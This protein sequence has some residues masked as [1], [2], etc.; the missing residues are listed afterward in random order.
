MRFAIAGDF[1]CVG[2]TDETFASIKAR[3]PTTGAADQL[4]LF[5]P[6]G[7]LSY[8]S[9]L[10]CFV[11]LCQTLGSGIFPNLIYPVIGNHDDEEDGSAAL[12]QQVINTFPNIPSRG[13]YAFTKGNIRFIGLDTQISYASGSAQHSFIVSELQAAAGNPAI[14]WKIVYYHKPSLIS[15]TSHEALTDFRNLYHP[16]FDTYKV[17]V[18]FTG[19]AHVYFRSKPVKHN[20]AAPA[21]PSRPIHPS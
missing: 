19:H 18:I 9:S 17:D 5:F 10:D 6:I 3:I 12:R 16:L 15:D 11:E 20:P 7:D 13:Y 8:G 2:D 1:D 14:K 4:G 21:S